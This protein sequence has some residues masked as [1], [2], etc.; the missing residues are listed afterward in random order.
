M[1]ERRVIVT[2]ER[3]LA[4][5]NQ[6]PHIAEALRSEVCHEE[7]EMPRTL[8]RNKEEMLAVWR[9]S[10]LE[11]DCTRSGQCLLIARCNFVA[12]QFH[13]ILV[14]SHEHDPAA[15]LR[16]VRLQVVSRPVR[17]LARLIT[18]DRLSPE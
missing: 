6:W 13:R 17:E 8:C 5:R 14:V 16:P 18:R 9:N 7:I 3:R 2:I 12:P 15:I 4:R 11:A 10:R 1:V